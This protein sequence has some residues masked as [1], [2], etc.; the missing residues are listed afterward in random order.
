MPWNESAKPWAL[1]RPQCCGEAL[2][3]ARSEEAA[4]LPYHLTVAFPMLSTPPGTSEVLET[5]V[6]LKDGCPKESSLSNTIIQN[7]PSLTSKA[8]VPRFSCQALWIRNTL[9]IHFRGPPPSPPPPEHRNPRQSHARDAPASQP[10]ERD[11]APMLTVEFRKGSGPGMLR[12]CSL[13][14]QSLLQYEAETK[15]GGGPSRRLWIMGTPPILWGTGNVFSF[16]FF[17][18]D[19]GSYSVFQAILDLT[20]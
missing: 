5:A 9:A 12:L 15:N 10:R 4:A 1:G 3:C 18:E 19:T 11:T 16:L 2:T 7:F 13:N 20:L 6:R 17:R 14:I 8:D